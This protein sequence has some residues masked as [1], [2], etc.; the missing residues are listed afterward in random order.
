MCV[1]GVITSRVSAPL[2]NCCTFVLGWLMDHLSPW[3]KVG[4]RTL[5]LLFTILFVFF[6]TFRSTSFSR[7][8]VFGYF[9]NIL[10]FRLLLLFARAST[11][12]HRLRPAPQSASPS[13]SCGRTHKSSS[14]VSTSFFIQTIVLARQVHC[15]CLHGI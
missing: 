7:T 8:I 6:A 9:H 15:C 2:L 3:W 10:L 1:H 12:L 5:L 4:R 13:N 11:F 14:L